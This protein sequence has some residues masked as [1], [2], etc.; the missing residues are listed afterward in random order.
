MKKILISGILLF[1]TVLS[2]FAQSNFKEGYII[3]NGNDTVHGLIDFRTDQVNTYACTFKAAEKSSET[4]YLPG[5]IA[6][7]RFENEGKYYVT[8]TVEIDGLKR[9][10]FLEF[11]LQG[12]LNLY[13]LPEGNGYYFFEGKDGRMVMTTMKP[14]KYTEDSKVIVDNRYKGIMTYVFKD[15]LPLATKTGKAK[16]DRRTMIEFTKEYHD[17]MCESGEKCIIFENDYKKK[18]TKFDFTAYS[19]V[20]TNDLKM[21]YNNYNYYY[22][23]SNIRSVSPVL[24]MEMDISS[25]RFMKSVSLVMDLNFSDF[26]GTTDYTYSNSI[27]YRYHFSGVKSNFHYGIKY[28]YYKGKIRPTLEAGFSANYLFNLKSTFKKNYVYRGEPT[29]DL[30]SENELLPSTTLTGYFAGIGLDYLLKNQH[31]IVA[32]FLYSI[33]TSVY[34]SNKTYQLKLGYRF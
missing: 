31:F 30:I 12:M 29:S 2:T 19:G 14:D 18:F 22:N 24:G 33:N 16:F 6:G 17:Q 21:D 4:L 15:D 27:Y 34:D 28:T 13:F 3:T 1:Y 20:E 23:F 10:V 7:F 25:P 11:L 26:A 5:E 32:R 8:R 9:T